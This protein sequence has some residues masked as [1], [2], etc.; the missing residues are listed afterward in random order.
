M[1]RLQAYGI[2]YQN[3]QVSHLHLTPRNPDVPDAGAAHPLSNEDDNE[4]RMQEGLLER[5][6]LFE[7]V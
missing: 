3:E 4:E 1:T 2:G 7:V 5:P 6:Y